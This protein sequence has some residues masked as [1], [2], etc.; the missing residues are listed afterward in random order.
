MVKMDEKLATY[1]EII[2]EM[3]HKV[4]LMQKQALE[5]ALSGDVN[6]ALDIIKMDEFVNNYEFEINDRA[7]EFLALLAPVA[8]D[9]RMVLCGIKIATDIERIGDYA[10]NIAQYVI[11]YG[12]LSPV[13]VPY[14]KRV[15]GVFFTMME[16]TLKAYHDLDE[17]AALKIPEMDKKIDA[18]MDEVYEKI[19]SDICSGRKFDNLARIMSVLRCYERAGDHTKN[20]NEHIIYQIKG[21]H[22]DFG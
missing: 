4:L 2:E 9:L 11:K 16:D 20:L 14:V 15:A 17:K 5:C 7:L 19:D 6:L 10:K 13:I 18:I 8:S 21:Q 1:Q 22:F 12:K 3:G